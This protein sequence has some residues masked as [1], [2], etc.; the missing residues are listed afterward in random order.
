MVSFGASPLLSSRT[1]LI[2]LG[3]NL[4]PPVSW[5]PLS[6]GR[7]PLGGQAPAQCQLISTV[8]SS[9]VGTSGLPDPASSVEPVL[10]TSRPGVWGQQGLDTDGLSQLLLQGRRPAWVRAGRG[11]WCWAG[12]HSVRPICSE[13]SEV[14][15]AM[16]E[17]HSSSRKSRRG[18]WRVPHMEEEPQQGSTGVWGHRG[19]LRRRL[20]LRVGWEWAQGSGR[21]GRWALLQPCL[22]PGLDRKSVV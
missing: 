9:C 18:E 14:V 3:W 1:P 22:Q 2:S 19:S 17:M 6:P 8:V 15:P 16:S 11:W 21:G 5:E 10:C 7:V 20:L 12:A 13:L 4:R